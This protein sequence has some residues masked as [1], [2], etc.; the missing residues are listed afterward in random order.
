MRRKLGALVMA[1]GFALM[2]AAGTLLGY[3]HSQDRAAEAAVEVIVPQILEKLPERPAQEN[4]A[5]ELIPVDYL[6]PEALEMTRVEIGGYDYVGCL[7]LP[8]LERELPVM[9]DWDYE[10]LGIA[11]CRYTG[12][13]NGRNLVIM[14]HNYASLFGGL[15]D[16]QPGDPVRFTDMDGRT[17][18]YQVQAMDLLPPT[19]VEE[20]TSGAFDLT[21]FTC[22]YGGENRVTVYCSRIVGGNQ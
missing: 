13:I 22:T 11:P 20:M 4:R 16:L 15:W 12:S 5:E 10:R 19:A 21:L 18:F 3:N 8:T 14:A 1:L 7:F 2:C 9:A 17:T 6:P